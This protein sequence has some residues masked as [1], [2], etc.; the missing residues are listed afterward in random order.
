MHSVW[1]RKKAT[2]LTKFQVHF[3]TSEVLS[4][5][6]NYS[7]DTRMNTTIKHTVRFNQVGGCRELKGNK[8]YHVVEL[9]KSMSP[10]DIVSLHLSRSFTT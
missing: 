6:A 10:L 8:N 3:W 4:I 5:G 7:S 9:D 1:L 2:C